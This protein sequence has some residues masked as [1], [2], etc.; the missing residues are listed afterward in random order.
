MRHLYQRII[1]EESNE[2]RSMACEVRRGMGDG[3][4]KLIEFIF[5]NINLESY[6]SY[7]K[8]ID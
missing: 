6:K 3:K 1:L 8:A 7:E 4:E 2:I 5:I